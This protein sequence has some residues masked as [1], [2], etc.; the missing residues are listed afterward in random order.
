MGKNFS[1]KMMFLGGVLS[2][3]SFCGKSAHAERVITDYEASRLTLNAL[4][5]PPMAHPS[6]RGRKRSPR[7]FAQEKKSS[8]NSYIQNVAYH[9]HVVSP[10]KRDNHHRRG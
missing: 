2:L 4:I 3:F 1:S 5:A 7:K 6:T 8:K 10:H 9:G